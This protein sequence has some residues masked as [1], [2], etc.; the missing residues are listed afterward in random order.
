M[1]VEESP[2]ENPRRSD[3]SVAILAGGQ[4]R[5]MGR[6]KAFLRFKGKP[7]LQHVIDAVMPLGLPV[8]LIANDHERY[9]VFNLPLYSDVVPSTGALGGVYTA[10]HVSETAYVLCLACD[11]PFVQTD[12]LRYLIRQIDASSDV[13]VPQF[14]GRYQPLHAIYRKTV[15]PFITE[16]LARNTLAIYDLYAQVDVSVILESTLQANR[17]DVRSFIN[18]NTPEEWMREIKMSNLPDVYTSIRETFPEIAEAY[19]SLGDAAHRAGPLDEQSRQLVKLALAIGAELEGATHAHTR[20]AL[21]MGITPDA[22][23]HVALLTITTLGFPSAVRALTWVN[24][25]LGEQ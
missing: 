7:L 6:D 18:L 23:R 4:S 2:T 24:D 17:Y 15:L 8:N 19:D 1:P 10:L 16:Q 14:G 22:I 3:V 12:L 9:A 21:E 25:I 11:M 5:R 13:I 20:R